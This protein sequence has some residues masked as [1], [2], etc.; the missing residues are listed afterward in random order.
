MAAGRTGWGICSAGETGSSSPPGIQ[1]S[2]L[3]PLPYPSAQQ[4]H[5]DDPKPATPARQAANRGVNTV[6]GRVHAGSPSRNTAR[7]RSSRARARA[8]ASGAQDPSCRWRSRP[9]GVPSGRAPRIGAGN[10]SSE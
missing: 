8:T 2:S 5:A 7:N 6:V 9:D 1:R 4:E 10:K 3:M